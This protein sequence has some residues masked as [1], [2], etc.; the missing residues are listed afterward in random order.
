MIFIS[1]ARVKYKKTPVAVPGELPQ[2]R[3]GGNREVNEHT[4][5]THFSG[6]EGELR[7]LEF[8]VSVE[9]IPQCKT[10][11]SACGGRGEFAATFAK[12]RADKSPQCTADS[13]T[14]G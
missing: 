11:D 1:G 3:S 9:I 5:P 10:E 13:V 4:Q 7:T 8:L 14:C 6:R 2:D 12:F